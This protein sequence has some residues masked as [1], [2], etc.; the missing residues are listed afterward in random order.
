LEVIESARRVT[1]KEIAIRFEPRRPGDPSHLVADATRAREVLGWQ[2]R[3]TLLDD[4]IRTAWEWRLRRP[5]G[6][7]EA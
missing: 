1:G 2:P 7:A 3:Y 6:Y 5:H 4:I